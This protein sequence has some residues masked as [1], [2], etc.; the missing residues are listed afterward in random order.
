MNFSQHNVASNAQSHKAVLAESGF[1]QVQCLHDAKMLAKWNGLLD[2]IFQSGPGQKRP[3]IY[4]DTLYK[5]G[6]LADIFNSNTV[7]L[8]EHLIPN[9]RIY[10]CH[11]YETAGNQTKSHIH[12][13][14]G[15]NGWHRD[16]ECLFAYESHTTHHLTLFINLTDISDQ[17]GPF[18]FSWVAPGKSLKNGA[19]SLK[20]TGKKGSTFLF[21][22][23]FYHRATPNHS[24]VRRRVIK[25][26][27][28]DAY[29]PNENLNTSTIFQA[30]QKLNKIKTSHITETSTMVWLKK[31]FGCYDSDNCHI[32]NNSDENEISV[33]EEL[34]PA[35][36][37]R[38]PN[39]KIHLSH[40]GQLK[41]KWTNIKVK[42]RR[43]LHLTPEK[44]KAKVLLIGSGNRIQNNFLPALQCVS[45]HF[46][47]SGIYSK[48]SSNAQ[49]VAEKWGIRAVEDLESVDFNAI[50]V[51]MIS[52]STHA[53][54]SILKQLQPHG[55][56]LHLLLDTPV[57]DGVHNALNLKLLRVFK[58]VQVAED[59]MNFP[60]FSLIRSLIS[61][62]CAGDVRSVRL[63]HTGYRYHGIALAKSLLGFPRIKNY[64]RIRP[65]TGL[66]EHHISFNNQTSAIIVQPYQRL[67][68][69]VIVE[70]NKANIIY[71]P[72][73]QF[74]DTDADS[75]HFFVTHGKDKHDGSDILQ[76]WHKG[77]VDIHKL[78]YFSMLKGLVT[79]YDKSSFNLY[80][81]EGLIHVMHAF[82]ETNM[83]SHYTYLDC[84][85]DNLS[86]TQ[87]VGLI[88]LLK[89]IIKG[90]KSASY[91]LLVSDR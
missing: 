23:N 52:I 79:D 63:E 82:K 19:P 32:E 44:P 87:S 42:E 59:F 35:I 14:N 34:L 11:A 77:N 8:I 13:D 62:Q 76:V 2:P 49:A 28:Q 37:H 9:A 30:A 71:E 68:G 24:N 1:L 73:Y 72:G 38:S 48:T 86:S 51:V 7:N 55:K 10:H 50:D 74:S 85:R 27:F 5:T 81:T 66:H 83:N 39:S 29:L 40:V 20:V 6:I 18:E 22:R 12:G 26:S 17:N 41:N 57:M 65:K 70:G 47:I 25:I 15:L 3:Y 4:S 21:D 58:N 36:M 88:S 61:K 67:D 54:P 64:T 78:G 45:D 84:Y 43:L 53:V 16:G 91:P 33:N 90:L 80:K 75:P 56:N 89:Y 69:R 31:F 46:E 60:Q